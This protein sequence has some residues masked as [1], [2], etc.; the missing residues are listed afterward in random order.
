M[1]TKAEL[2][3]EEQLRG[4]WAYRNQVNKPSAEV[5][6]TNDLKHLGPLKNLRQG[7]IAADAKST[8]VGEV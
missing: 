1:A 2:Q 6:N 5:K 3:K 7:F 8:A 4:W